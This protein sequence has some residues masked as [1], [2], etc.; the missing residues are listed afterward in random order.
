MLT[1]YLITGLALA[2][3]IIAMVLI[4]QRRSVAGGR[5]AP[6]IEKSCE[7]CQNQ[8]AEIERPIV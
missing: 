4:A 6:T 8:Q 1:F 7:C 5:H 3:P 2:L